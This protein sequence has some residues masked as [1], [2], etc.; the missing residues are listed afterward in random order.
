[1]GVADVRAAA[2][3]RRAGNTKPVDDVQEDE[4]KKNPPQDP[5][6]SEGE[7]EGEEK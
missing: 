1:M 2:I 5:S 4:E 6:E 3:A 7:S